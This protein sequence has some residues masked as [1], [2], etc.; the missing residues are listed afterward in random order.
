MQ[1]EEEPEEFACEFEKLMSSQVASTQWGHSMDLLALIT[2]DHL[3]ELY[4]IS[5]KAQRVFQ[6]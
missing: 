5:Y 6:S 3:V 2:F 1:A 4:R